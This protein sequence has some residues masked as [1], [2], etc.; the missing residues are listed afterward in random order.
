MGVQM[1]KNHKPDFATMDITMPSENGINDGIDAV[2]AIKSEF[3]EAKIVMITSHGEENKVLDAIQNGASNYILKP[4][5][6]EKLKEVI[7]KII[8]IS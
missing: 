4:I 6:I 8:H 3:P 7:D 2:K 1:Y 5:K